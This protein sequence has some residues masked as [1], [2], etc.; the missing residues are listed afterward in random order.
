MPN[1]TVNVPGLALSHTKLTVA[2]VPQV[3]VLTNLSLVKKH[4]RLVALDDM[5]V[6]KAREAE[7]ALEVKKRKGEEAKA[8]EKKDNPAKKPRTG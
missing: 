6:A 5:V 1:V 8:K 2:E 3:N 7:K 4:T